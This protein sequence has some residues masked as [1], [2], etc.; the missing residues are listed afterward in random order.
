MP[1]LFPAYFAYCAG[2][3]GSLAPTNISTIMTK[4][5]D[6]CYGVTPNIKKHS[7]SNSR[8]LINTNPDLRSNISDSS[9]AASI[10][11]APAVTAAA[12]AAATSTTT[13]PSLTRSSSLRNSLLFR[14]S[15]LKRQTSSSPSTKHRRA[16]SNAS[17]SDNINTSYCSGKRDSVLSISSPILVSESQQKDPL[18]FALPARRAPV[19]PFN[20]TTSQ[21][22]SP[23]PNHSLNSCSSRHLAATKPANLKYTTV[24]HKRGEFTMNNQQHQPLTRFNSTSRMSIESSSTG[25]SVASSDGS[26]KVFSG[27]S[28][29]TP[30]SSRQPSQTNVN[31]ACQLVSQMSI[32]NLPPMDDIWLDDEEDED[33]DEGN[34]MNLIKKW[35]GRKE[36]RS[37]LHSNTNSL[38]SGTSMTSTAG[39][40]SNSFQKGPNPAMSFT[41]LKRLA[42]R[43]KT[44]GESS[45]PVREPDRHPERT[46]SAASGHSHSSSISSS[47]STAKNNR[48]K[49]FF[50]GSSS[51]SVTKDMISNPSN[52]VHTGHLDPFTLKGMKAEAPPRSSARISSGSQ[53]STSISRTDSHWRE[54]STSSTWSMNS[55]GQ[56]QWENNVSG[57]PATSAGSSPNLQT[58]SQFPINGTKPLNINHHMNRS[59]ATVVMATPNQRIV[60]NKSS[61]DSFASW[62]ATPN[63]EF[64]EQ[65]K[66]LLHH[67]SE[68]D[69]MTN[70]SAAEQ[71]YS[72]FKTKDFAAT[73]SMVS[74]QSIQSAAIPQSRHQT[75]KE[76]SDR[77]ASMLLPSPVISQQYD[78]NQSLDH[79][80]TRAQRQG[81][82]CME[83]SQN[84][85]QNQNWGPASALGIMTENDSKWVQLHSPLICNE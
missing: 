11:S 69:S 52:F 23:Q 36:S 31:Q 44:P 73:N 40:S 42:G 77:K 2:V 76:A 16:L 65:Q 71:P 53:T 45:S 51:Q 9:C 60:T 33:D 62:S 15:S 25:V 18:N 26:S 78:G 14:S 64:V 63:L 20:T 75:L 81:Y 74:L 59:T 35:H 17:L 12:A 24:A 56:H 41:N 84:Q 55:Y 10:V 46:V 67:A 1:A 50:N 8:L 28:M 13:T 83:N 82:V 5:C 66:W 27:F 54:N 58:E 47:A 79:N 39:N 7:S 22:K 29:G 4:Q 85:N 32:S 21:P 37:T 70:I 61:R 72:G 57:T 3:Q 6:S 48:F 43:K 34:K 49:K 80:V 38:S 68:S 19:V 30:A